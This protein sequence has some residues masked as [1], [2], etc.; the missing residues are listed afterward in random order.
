MTKT[1]TTLEP[2]DYEWNALWG[3]HVDQQHESAR[4]EEYEDA[5]W[6]KMRAGE[7]REMLDAKKAKGAA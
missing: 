6:H 7:I 5:K 3:W 2:T 4:K 1:D